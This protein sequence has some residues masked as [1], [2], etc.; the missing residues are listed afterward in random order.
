VKLEEAIEAAQRTD[1]VIHILLVVPRDMAATPRGAQTGGSGACSRISSK[2][3]ASLFRTEEL[4]SRFS[5]RAHGGC[6]HI[7]G[8]DQQ[9]VNHGIQCAGPLDR[10]S[11]FTLLPRPCASVRGQ[12]LCA[13]LPKRVFRCTP[14]RSAS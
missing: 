12:L 11:S 5:A 8:P 2:S 1:T 9:N 13:R 14:G 7:A 3:F 4:R 6:R 10:F